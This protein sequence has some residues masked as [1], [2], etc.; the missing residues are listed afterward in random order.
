MYRGPVGVARSVEELHLA[1]RVR[2]RQPSRRAFI[3]CLLCAK[4]VRSLMVIQCSQMISGA[5]ISIF[6]GE[7]NEIVKT[8]Q[9]TLAGNDRAK[10]EFCLASSTVEG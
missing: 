5:L 9:L 3:H 2:E 8:K 7:Q 1:Q 10:F 4:I 6:T